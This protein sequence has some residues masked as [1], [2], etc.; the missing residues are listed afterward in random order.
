MIIFYQKHADGPA[1]VIRAEGI[2]DG[3]EIGQLMAALKDA[4]IAHK[5]WGLDGLRIELREKSQT[6]SIAI[7][8]EANQQPPPSAEF[9]SEKLRNSGIES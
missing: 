6:S 5:K 3:I 2:G 8:Q 7:G 1:L 4:G 9:F